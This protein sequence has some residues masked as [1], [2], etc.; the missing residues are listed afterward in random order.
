MVYSCTLSLAQSSL[1]SLK[2]VLFRDSL[3]TYRKLIKNRRSLQKYQWDSVTDSPHLVSHV[4]LSVS[5]LLPMCLSLVCP[6]PVLHIPHSST[7]TF[8]HVP[9]FFMSLGL[10]TCPFF[11]RE[12]LFHPLLLFKHL[13]IFQDA[14]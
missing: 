1:T 14:G 5:W 11:H 4:M 12:R 10:C 13:L 7:V 2:I 3:K 9:P 8:F 6:L